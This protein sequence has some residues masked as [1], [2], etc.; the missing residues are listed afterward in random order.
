VILKIVS[1]AFQR[2]L[3]GNAIPFQLIGRSNTTE[4]E[5]LGRVVCP[6]GEDD[7]TEAAG[8]LVG[9]RC[10]SFVRLMQGS[11]SDARMEKAVCAIPSDS[12]LDGTSLTVYVM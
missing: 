1:Y 11:L 9:S 10:E 7:P 5:D 2:H 4:H 3:D 8:G 6:A 12:R